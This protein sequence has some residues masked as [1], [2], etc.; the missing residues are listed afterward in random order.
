MYFL[1]M[2]WFTEPG[3]SNVQLAGSKKFRDGTLVEDKRELVLSPAVTYHFLVVS[4]QT[5]IYKYKKY[6][7][8]GL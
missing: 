8:K 6:K 4:G 7:F 5:P 1:S 3:M 2:D